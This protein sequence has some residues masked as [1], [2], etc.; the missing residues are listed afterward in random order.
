MLGCVQEFPFADFAALPAAKRKKGNPKSKDKITYLNIVTA[1]DIETSR[2]QDIE[3]S[4]MYVWQWHFGPPLNYTVIGRTWKEYADFV[5]DISDLCGDNFL[6]VYVHNL[7]YEFQF[8]R[9][10][11]EWSTDDVF[12]V[13]PRKPLKATHDQLEFRCS[14]LHSNMR[15]E[16]YLNK[17]GTEHRKLPDYDYVGVR[18]PWTPL[19]DFELEYATNDVIGLVEA[20]IIEMEHDKDNLYTIPLT[21]TGYVRRD[22][23]AAMRNA[24]RNLIS[25]I[26]PNMDE[27]EMLRRAFRGGNT[28]AN[29]YLVARARE[30]GEVLHDVR[31]ADISSDYPDKQCNRKFPISKFCHLT[32]CSPEQLDELIYKRKRAVCCTLC[33]TNVRLRKSDW[34]VPNISRS[35]CAECINAEIDNGRVLSADYLEIT[36]TDIDYKIF[37]QEYLWDDIY[38]SECMHARYGYLPR[39]L[40]DCIIDYYKQKTNLKGIKEQEIYY[41]KL[42]N[43]LNAIYG[44]SAQ[45]PGKLPQIF[46]LLS[47]NTWALD[48]SKPLEEIL[49]ESNRRAAEPYQWGVWTTAYARADL[50]EA[51]T[52]CYEQGT[53]VYCDT[54]SVYYQGD[55]DFSSFNVARET[56]SKRSGAFATDTKGKTH[57]MGVLENDGEYADFVTLGAKKYVK[58]KKGGA[59]QATIA[60]VAKDE[61]NKD[62][63]IKKVGGGIEL[64]RAGGISAF[65]EGFTFRQAGGLESVYNDKSYGEC[66]VDGHVLQIGP[67]T[68]LR[69]STYTIGYSKDYARL[70]GMIV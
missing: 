48:T 53:F 65:R 35:R 43:K 63:S 18:Y 45:D 11:W 55:V 24:P 13:G 6:V 57:Y 36:C 68:V 33:L 67:N 7:S 8:L 17:M 32:E 27:Y 28:H 50:E 60:G 23:K 14:Y 12:A 59:L 51:I 19:T 30:D 37:V 40:V 56:M 64:E 42:K 31:C 52:L 1:F 62:G 38:V 3:Q 41:G 29:R 25:S 44:M 20:L 69:P 58:R 54:D 49:A 15:L 10:V 21:S 2:L 70:L 46:T 39:A 22:V 9:N 61:Y 5:Q 16:T 4:I 47:E 26:A 66:R 34:P